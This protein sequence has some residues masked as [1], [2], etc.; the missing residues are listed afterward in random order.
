M[1]QDTQSICRGQSISY[2]CIGDGSIMQMYSPPI[3]NESGALT[4]FSSDRV[5]TCN[6]IPNS[7]AA[8]VFVDSTGSSSFMGTLTLYISNTISAG[9]LNVFCRVSTAGGMTVTNSTT[10]SVLGKVCIE[11]QKF[12]HVKYIRYMS[13]CMLQNI[14]KLSYNYTQCSKPPHL[15]SLYSYRRTKCCN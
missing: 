7:A 12:S 15:A 11:R 4:L 2:N 14:Y 9:L 8:I 13:T 1:P 3:V 6:V 5:Q 10:F